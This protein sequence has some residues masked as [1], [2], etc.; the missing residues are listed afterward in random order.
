MNDSTSFFGESKKARLAV[1]YLM[2]AAITVL[3]YSTMGSQVSYHIL[4]RELF[5]IPIVLVSFWYGLKKGFYT[6]L[7]VV[8]LYS[9]HIFMTWNEQPGVNVGNLLQLIVFIL[10]AMVTGHLSNREK[11]RH[12]NLTEAQNLA[13]LG[14]A[15]LGM[16]SE[17][18]EVLKTLRVLES[19]SLSFA[20]QRLNET[21]HGAIEKISILNEI[22]SKFRPGQ[23]GQQRNFVEINGAIE[24][25]REKVEEL[26]KARGVTVKTDVDAAL[27]LLRINQEDLIGILEELIRNAVEH[28]G[29]GTTVTIRGSRFEDRHEITVTD[30]GHGIPPENLSKI[31]VPFFT[32]KENGTG[33]GLSVCRKMMRDKGGDVL[34][35]SKPGEGSTFT[36]VFSQAV[37]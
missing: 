33:L 36:L 5:L 10:V 8:F 25:A 37:T 12:R 23:K 27:G 9:P 30:Q 19:S 3:H 18:Q 34:V 14:R 20:D 15:T 21:M 35:E 16:T 1:V 13:T 28:S 7:F 24:R 11:E 6:A 29:N 2:I 17:L 32:T 31:F 26:A 22:L 4:Y